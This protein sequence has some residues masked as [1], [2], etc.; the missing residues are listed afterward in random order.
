MVLKA[1]KDFPGYSICSETQR[2]WSEKRGIFL[3]PKITHYGYYSVQLNRKCRLIHRL[4]ALAFIENTNPSKLIWIDHINR[5]RLD[6]RPE[7]LR[8][9]SE[10]ENALNRIDNIA[11]PHIYEKCGAFDVKFQVKSINIY[12]RFFT[13]D[14][15]LEFH[16]IIQD[17]I[18][19]NEPVCKVFV[20]LY[21]NQQKFIHTLPS[22][23]IMLQIRKSTLKH[24]Q[25]F[26]TLE[27]AQQIRD[28]L[29]TNYYSKNK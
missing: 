5:N 11:Y 10:Q 20:E 23:K 24:Y 28:E 1:I 4:F 12:R 6:N 25:L 15:A 22:G 3:K 27:Q 13:F 21:D 9:V 18:D 29:L 17:K 26:S 8:W 2:V 19:I 16:D 7:N 14:K